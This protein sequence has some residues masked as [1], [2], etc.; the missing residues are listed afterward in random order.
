MRTV[1]ITGA[2][3]NMGEPVAR[4]FLE[5]GD[6][7]VLSGRNRERLN[8]LQGSFAQAAAHSGAGGADPFER[9]EINR[10]DPGHVGGADALVEDVLGRHGRVDC[11][12]H[13][14]GLFAMKTVAEAE[15]LDWSALM[16]TNA[17][18]AAFLLKRLLPGMVE[19]GYGK[20]VFVSAVPAHFPGAGLGPYAASKVALEAIAQAAAQ[21][22]KG[23]GVNVN[24]V[25][26]TTLDTPEARK[27]M[28]DV[29]P[30]RFIPADDV[31]GTILFL[32]SDAATSINGAVVPLMGRG[33]VAVAL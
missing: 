11:F 16:T 32:C 26:I 19:R 13:L 21:E 15:E 4:A 5:A 33:G 20:V 18:S 29:D 28:P 12:V 23:S 14:I 1:L 7:V 25:A 30:S 27:E 9:V 17:F 10:S 6:E 31:A 22:V 2:T 8:E 3:G 24:V